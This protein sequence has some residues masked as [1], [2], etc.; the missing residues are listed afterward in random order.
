MAYRDLKMKDLKAKFGI[1]EIGTKLF[2]VDKI[3]PIE[4]SSSLLNKLA[5]AQYITLSTEKAVSEQLVAPVLV[6]I[7]KLNDFL[8]FFRVRLF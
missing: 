1:T 5:D 3:K 2:N 4:P 7:A 6:E 8:Q